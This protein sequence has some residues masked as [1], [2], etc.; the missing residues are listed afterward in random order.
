MD[1]EIWKSAQR[2]EVGLLSF[3]LLRIIGTSFDVRGEVPDAMDLILRQS[4]L[5]EPERIEPLV[6]ATFQTTV[7]QI[8]GVDVDIGSHAD[9]LEKAKAASSA[10]SLPGQRTD[11]GDRA[12]MITEGGEGWVVS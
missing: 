5:A 2:P 11:R 10:A 7:V 1:G 9:G 3:G 8:E 6:R 4:G 12:S